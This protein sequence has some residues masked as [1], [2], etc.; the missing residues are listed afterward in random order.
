MQAQEAG[1]LRSDADP[2]IIVSM[3]IALPHPPIVRRK[4]LCA[5]DYI[6]MLMQGI[7]P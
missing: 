4:R 6:D 7:A 1:E 2:Q 3:L 5:E